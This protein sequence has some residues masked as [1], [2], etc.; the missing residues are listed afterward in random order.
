M[1]VSIKTG[2]TNEVRIQKQKEHEL[3]RRRGLAGRTIVQSVWLI[4]SGIVGYLLLRMLFAEGYLSYAFFY[5][6]LGIPTA[7][8]RAVILGALVLIVMVIMQFFLV[9]G[10]TM[11]SPQGR[12]RTGKP[13][14]HSRNP[15]PLEREYRR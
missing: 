7:I 1:A 13:T 3:A 4:T 11:M 6:D 15:D 5:G 9:F 2:V 12:A 10:F 8:P 14:A